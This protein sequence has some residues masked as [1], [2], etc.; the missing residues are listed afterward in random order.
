MLRK[1][2]ALKGDI[3]IARGVQSTLLKNIET[4]P[5]WVMFQTEKSKLEELM[6]DVEYAKESNREFSSV[7][8]N[9]D[10][11]S[12]RRRFDNET[13]IKQLR[14]FEKV[15]APALAKLKALQEKLEKAHDIMMT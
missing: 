12:L 5:S 15:V 4:V 6:H 10:G 8:M 1:S 11:P 3:L 2:T 7:F 14:D 9:S 13:L